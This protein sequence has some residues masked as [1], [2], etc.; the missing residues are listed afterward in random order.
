MAYEKDWQKCRNI[1]IIQIQNKKGG[2]KILKK[3]KLIQHNHG[4]N[5]LKY[6]K[7]E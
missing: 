2:K 5:F 4:F 3:K 6:C 7:M 1:I